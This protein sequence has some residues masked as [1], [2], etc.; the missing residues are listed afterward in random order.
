LRGVYVDGDYV[1]GTI[2]GFRYQRGRVVEQG[3]LLKQP[4]NI[5]SF[6]QA[7]DG[8]LYVLTSAGAIFHIVPPD[9]P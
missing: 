8:E 2:W 7:Q 3:T 6:A 5:T 1:L 9:S 4:K